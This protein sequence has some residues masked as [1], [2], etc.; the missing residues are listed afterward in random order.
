MNMLSNFAEI[1]KLGNIQSLE[2]LLLMHN[3]LK[4]IHLP[5][6]EPTQH[7]DI[8]PNLLEINLKDNPIENEVET[9]NELDKLQHLSLVNQTP[10]PKSGFENMFSRAVGLISNLKSF[11]KNNVNPISRR[12]AEYDIWK[13][14]GWEYLLTSGSPT[15]RNKFMRKIRAYGRIVESMRIH[16]CSLPLSGFEVVFIFYFAEYGC[17]DEALV[18][19]ATKQSSVITVNLLDPEANRLVTKKLPKK[20]MIQALQGL[21]IKLFK[22][23]PGKF[24]ILSYVDAERQDVCVVLDNMSKTLD[25][26]SIQDGDTIIIQW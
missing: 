9:F 2:V 21:V 13:Q 15:D 16:P 14:Y 26:Y 10:D 17:P 22:S 25:Y 24:P 3:G 7:L 12:E 8:F 19:P 5:D 20:M 1:L 23:E 11:N 6:C 4:R 18:R